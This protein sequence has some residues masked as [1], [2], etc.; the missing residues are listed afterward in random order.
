MISYAFE[1]DNCI[2]RWLS[3]E[4]KPRCRLRLKF[5]NRVINT[6]RPNGLIHAYLVLGPCPWL[7][8]QSALSLL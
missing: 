3:K 1:K 5:D 2:I 4:S 7:L 8:G 6:S